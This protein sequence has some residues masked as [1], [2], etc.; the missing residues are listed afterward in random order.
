MGALW[1]L[2]FEPAFGYVPGDWGDPVLACPCS[3]SPSS[4][5]PPKASPLK[6]P[7]LP[8]PDPQ[9]PLLALLPRPSLCSSWRR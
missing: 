8:T 7:A 9:P 1:V 3:L 6:L 5:P 2:M 4:P